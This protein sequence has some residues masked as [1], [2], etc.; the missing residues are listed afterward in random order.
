MIRMVVRN[1]VEDFARWKS[2]FDAQ[3]EAARQAGLSLEH[4]W[5][6][7]EDANE[8]FF[9]FTVADINKAKAFLSAP[10]AAETGRRAGVSDG[11]YWF[12]E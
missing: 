4:L 11:N 9:I 12:V 6:G 1:K 10:E 7:V 5:R 2:V 8:V 3:S